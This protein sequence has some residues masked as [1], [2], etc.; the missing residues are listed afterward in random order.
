MSLPATITAKPTGAS[1]TPHS[2]L[3]V[4]LACK[5]PPYTTRHAIIVLDVLP[6]RGTRGGE[7]SGSLWRASLAWHG[8][9][10]VNI[11][12]ENNSGI[13]FGSG[14]GLIGLN[15]SQGLGLGSGLG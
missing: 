3:T 7:H 12:I 10:G 13:V 2:T 1:A 5:A 6:A 8:L 14:T 9:I 11:G 15:A 4:H